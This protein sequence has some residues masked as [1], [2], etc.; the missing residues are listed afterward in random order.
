LGCTPG[1]LHTHILIRE[2]KPRT[3]PERLEVLVHELGHFL[4]ACHSPEFDSVM[5]PK[6]GDGRAILRSFRIGFDPLNTL[7]MNLV[8]E[9]LARRPVRQ[10]RELR[11]R[12]RQ[13]LLDI[14]STV[15]RAMPD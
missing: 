13:R 9:E 8:A 11:P 10:L 7:V 14:F 1:P 15:L 6:L 5:R 4:G 3:E 12:T 2:R